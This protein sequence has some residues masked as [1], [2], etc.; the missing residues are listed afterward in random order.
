MSCICIQI[1]ILNDIGLKYWLDAGTLLGIIRD[2]DLIPWDYDADI[3]IL[4]ET[5]HEIMK[6]RIKF[7]PKYSINSD[8][9]D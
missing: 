5:S 4:P 9:F 1:D 2:G 6:H 8:G 7:L 3:G